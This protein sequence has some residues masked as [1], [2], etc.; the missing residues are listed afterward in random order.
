MQA[1][2]IDRI[3]SM[4]D[5]RVVTEVLLYH[6]AQ[7]KENFNSLNTDL[8]QKLKKSE[9]VQARMRFMDYYYR[10]PVKSYSST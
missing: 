1:V 5:I 2:I 3:L 10:S 8:L 4:E 6:T 9:E 7:F